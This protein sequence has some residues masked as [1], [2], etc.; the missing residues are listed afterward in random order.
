MN[1]HMTNKNHTGPKWVRT[2]EPDE[3]HQATKVPSC[4]T[5]SLP[6]K[7]AKDALNWQLCHSLQA[8]NPLSPI[9]ATRSS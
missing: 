1:S 3:E 8:Y 2:Q 6:M 9:L 7:A 5:P 4:S